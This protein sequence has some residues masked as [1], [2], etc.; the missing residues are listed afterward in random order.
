MDS[1]IHIL[2]PAVLAASLLLAAAGPALAAKAYSTGASDTEI[3]IGNTVPYSGHL[4]VYGLIGRSQAAYFKMLNDQGG[5]NG[6]KVTFISYDDAYSPPKTLEQV[7]KL[8]ESDGVL[9]LSGIVG[10]PTNTAV[11]KYLNQK[12]IPQLFAGSGAAKFSDPKNAPWT[13]GWIPAYRAEGEIYV[14]D[15]LQNNP[16]AKIGVVYQNDDFGKDYLSG[17]KAG[18][19]G[20]KNVLVEAPFETT[21]PTLDSQIVSL[22]DSGADAL[23][24]VGIGKFASQAIRK[25]AELGWKPVRYVTNTAI[26]VDTV[27]KP[28]GLENAAGLISVAYKKDPSDP[29]WANDPAMKAYVAFMEKYLPGEPKNDQSAFGYMQAKTLEQVLRQCGDNLTRENVMAQ[30]ASLKNVDLPL[31]LPGITLNTSPTDFSPIK[32]LQ[33]QRFDGHHWK[34][35]GSLVTVN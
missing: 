25:A 20:K 5:L 22:K 3:K 35:F 24:I 17:V 29:E 32:K 30:A 23:I 1:F 14:K 31:L 28:A 21:S 4:S 15:I 19:A 33:T 10:S 7:R 27:L 12:K 6:R 18:L 9:A 26:S 11:M 34:L 2:R 8:V 13:M 16:V